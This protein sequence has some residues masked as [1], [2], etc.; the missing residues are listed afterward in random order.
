MFSIQAQGG[1]ISLCLDCKLKLDQ[2]IAIQQDLVER[3]LNYLAAEVESITG[4]PGTVPRYP[5]R[6]VV[7][8]DQVTQHNVSVSNSSIGVLNT[9][10]LQMVNSAAVSLSQGGQKELSDA[11]KTLAD[12][13][14]R[15]TQ[16]TKEVQ[17][18]ALEI[19]SFIS[20]EATVSSEK[21][22]RFA[23]RPLLQEL[24]NLC[25][26]VAGLAQLWQQFG[27]M[28]TSWFK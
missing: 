6:Q 11:I 2:S 5:M 24:A 12:G 20:S 26:G 23:I 13:I 9:G 27:P 22:R 14:A 18:K 1:Q 3:N 28:I 17:D 7:R 25:S 19:L 8:A 15:N 10:S 16:V 4:L 21:R